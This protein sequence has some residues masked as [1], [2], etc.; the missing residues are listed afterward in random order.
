MKPVLMSGIIAA[1]IL[2]ATSSASAGPVGVP[3]YICTSS[4]FPTVCPPNA[5]CVPD[6][7]Q[8]ICR[9]MV[10]ACVRGDPSEPIMEAKCFWS[11]VRTRIRVNG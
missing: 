11:S 8:K 3:V 9:L 10:Y 2:A 4:P 6:K 1:A 7:E 5:I